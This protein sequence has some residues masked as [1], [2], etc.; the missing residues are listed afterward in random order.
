MANI[1]KIKNSGTASSAPS[2]LE[3]GEL[4]LNYADGKLYYKDDGGSITF[5]NQTGPTGPSG[6]AGAKGQ[7]GATGAT[8]S[9]GSQ[10]EKGAT[11]ATGP[12]GSQGPTGPT[13]PTGTQGDAGAAGPTGSKGQKGATG[14]T[15][16]TGPGGSTGPTGPTGS[17]GSAGAKGQKGELG[18]TGPTGP[19]GPSGATTSGSNNQILT[20]DG[21][22]GITSESSL[23]FSGTQLT[24]TGD[25][26]ITSGSLGVNTNPPSGDGRIRATSYITAG[27]GTGGVALTH[28]DGYG[29]ANVTFNHEAG[30]PEQNG[31]SARIEVNTDATS[32]EALMSFE[33]SASDVTSGSAQGLTTSFNIAHDYIEMP[34]MLRHMGDTDTYIQYDANRIYLVAGG[35]TKYDSNNGNVIAT[36]DIL[37]QDDMS[38]NSATAVASQQSIKAYVDAEVAGIVNS[39][40]AA[41]NTLDELAA[42]LGDDANFATTTSTSLGNRLRVDTASQGLTGTQQANAITNLGITATKAELNYVDGVTSNIQTQL[43]GKQASGSYLT[44]SSNLNASNLSSG[45]VNNARLNTDMQLTSAAPRYRLQESDVTNTPNWW[46]IADGGNMSFRLNNTGTYPLVFQTNGTNDAVT[47]INLGYGTAI[48]GTLEV[49][50]RITATGTG[51]FTIGNHAGY[52]RIQNSSNSFSFLTDGNGYADMTFGTVTA[53]TWQGTA[54]A[55]AYVADLPASKITSGTFSSA[56]MPASFAADSVTQDDITNR[57]ESGFYQTASGTTGEG[58][59][60]TNNTYQHMIA[61][62]HSNDSNYYS[63]QIAGSFYDQNFYGRKTNGSGTRSWLR[64]ITTADEG[65]GNGFDADTVDGIQASGFTRAGVESGTP[66]TAANKTTFTCNDAIE[67]SSGNQSGL[68]VWQDTSGADAFMTFHVAGDYAGYFGLDGSTNDLSWGGWSNGNGNKYRVFHAGNSTN[69]TSV[70]TINTGTWNGS[71]IAS[72]YLDADTAHLSGTQTFSGTKTFSDSVRI[73]GGTKYL[74]LD[75]D[76]ESLAGIWFRDNQD[77]G[78]QYAKIFFNSGGSNPLS[79]YVKS[80]TAVLQLASSTATVNG[81]IAVSG[82]VDGRDVASDGSKLDGIESGATADQTAAQILT[83]IKTVDGSGSG[84]DA[85]TLDGYDSSRFFRRQ[86]SASATVGPGWMTV[87]TNTSGRQAGEILVTDGDSGDHGFIRIHWLRSYQDSNFTVINCGGHQNRIT[88]VRVLSQDSD[89][90]YGEKILQVYVEANSAYEAKIF[91]MGDNTH[92]GDHTVHTPTIENTITGYS[93]HGHQLENLSTY[94]FAHEEGILAG[95]NIEADRMRTGTGT[96]A[97]PAYS[98]EADTDTGMLRTQA[99]TIGFATGGSTRFSMSS[100]GVFY[101]SSAI[102]AGNAGV[103][104]WDGTHGFK[105]VL[106]KD[107]TYTTLLNNDGN[108]MIHLGDSGDA[109]SYFQAG[110]HRFRNL[111]GSAYYARIGSGYIRGEGGGSVG[112]PQFSFQNDPNTGMYSLGADDLGFSAGGVLRYGIL[113]GL[114]RFYA[115]VV[116]GPNN[117]NSKP[118]IQY[119]DGYD[120]ASTPSYS[121]YYDN[122]CGMGHP[123][124]STIAFSTASVERLR[125]N[126]SGLTVTGDMSVNGHLTLQ[127]GHYFTAHNESSYNKY[128]MYAGS[129]AYAIGMY[130]GNAFGGLNDWAMTFTFNDEADRGFLWRDTAHSQG[131]GAMSLTTNGKLAVAHSTRIGYGESDTTT[132]GATYRL[133]VSGSIGATADVVAYVSSD[134]RLKDNIKNIANPLEKLEKLNG[135]EFDWN[136]K[137]DLYKGH[138]IGVIAQE[139]EEVLPEIVDTRKD[140]HKAV[141]YDRMVALLIEAVKEQQQ[142]INELKEKLNG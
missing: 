126:N 57:A 47:G 73:T 118:Y 75:N 18:V 133:D 112:T 108:V 137:Q 41:L 49:N 97:F 115:N 106:A 67:T 88:G 86:G 92:Y 101:A 29:N 121:W 32:S 25:I 140:G 10:G 71:V 109:N 104:I 4:A 123:A 63:M 34:K 96:A 60:I 81:N 138:D 12:T 6:A 43:N 59:P 68:Q 20:D 90:T 85:D 19:T 38:S 131:Q 142:Q 119:K 22:G 80:S 77:Q 102:Q 55:N 141:K 27:Y 105:T 54:I 17:A 37:D 21:S 48:N 7:K 103:Q 117:N 23:T 78:G 64:F 40:P 39:A 100:A 53:G 13:G 16:P 51:G 28:N 89:N 130:S 94:G 99:D 44:S 129:S 46:M 62:T 84:L 135:V 36:G 134:K 79:F 52:D 5:F 24:N 91:R 2:D 132:P 107:S 58:W 8:G 9:A 83:A 50:N 98:F 31:Q 82:T 110:E 113:N 33:T 128:S 26:K 116:V 56:R 65:S 125:I 114:N 61:T 45:T 30:T 93:L 3:V 136:D 72:A 120:T 66:N 111:A 11:G 76:D 69:I 127:S 95:G 70:G 1:L 87:A 14:A 139:V 15:G 35:T 74:Y 42:A 122:G 124:G